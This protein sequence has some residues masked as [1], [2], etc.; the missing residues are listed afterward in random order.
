MGSGWWCYW[1]LDGLPRGWSDGYE[2]LC[3]WCCTPAGVLPQPPR[4]QEPIGAL[5]GRGGG[6][7]EVVEAACQ[8]GRDARAQ[9]F[10]ISLFHEPLAHPLPVAQV[11][12]DDVVFE[13]AQRTMKVQAFCELLLKEAFVT[14]PYPLLLGIQVDRLED[15]DLKIL[16]ST[17]PTFL[18]PSYRK[19]PLNQSHSPED[20]KEV[21]K[22]GS[23]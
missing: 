10:P 3:R 15:N 1:A 4:G 22:H 12:K 14:T 6:T 17:L 19:L 9:G 16:S 21:P 23:A 13:G 7:G 11:T 18:G 8:H 2:S 5:R 20:L